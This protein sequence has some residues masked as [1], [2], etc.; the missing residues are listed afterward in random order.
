[1]EPH[2]V[3]ELRRYRLRPGG[4]EPLIRLFDSEFVEPQEALGMRIVGEFRDLED[5]DAFVWVRSFADMEVRTEA[6]K[7]FYTS[8][9]WKEHG[10]AA[11]DT[12]LNSDNVLL[13]KPVRGVQP[14]SHN[15]P[16]KGEELNTGGLIV[17]NICSLAPRTEDEFAMFFVQ[18]ALPILQ[19]TG[20][21]VDALFVTERSVN[22]F[23][24]LPV[25]EGEAVLVWFECHEN[26]DSFL[27]HRERLRRNLKWTDDVYPRIDGQ[28]W[29]RIEVAR[30]TPTSRS[31]CT[32]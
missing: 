32:W 28:C 14:F 16:R 8:A 7:S 13:L 30:L 19:D 25:R 11:N 24:R 26:D 12:M 17:V 2:T 22:G 21:R 18:N 1:M 9:I 15:L 4:R 29:R 3:F 6:L 10:P 20:A 31:L 5:P 27:H 23:P